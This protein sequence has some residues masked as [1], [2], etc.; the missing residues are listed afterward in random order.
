LSLEERLKALESGT[1]AE[2]LAALGNQDEEG[3]AGRPNPRLHPQGLP[4]EAFSYEPSTMWE[5]VASGG[6][7]ALRSALLALPELGANL[8]E[9]QKVQELT[10]GHDGFHEG[11][12]AAQKGVRRALGVRDAA[13]TGVADVIGGDV[14]GN[15]PLGALVEHVAGKG[16]GAVREL[17]QE[18]GKWAGKLSKEELATL[19]KAA[20]KDTTESAAPKKVEAAA[21]AAAAPA[22]NEAAAAAERRI[23]PDRRAVQRRQIATELNLPEDHPAVDRLVSRDYD[24]LTG[25]MGRDAY[26]RA[27]TSG[28]APAHVSEFDIAGMGKINGHPELGEDVSDSIL[29][30]TGRA[31]D[32]M[33]GDSGT[34]YRKGGDEFVVHWNDPEVAKELH[35]KLSDALANAEVVHERPDGTVVKWRGIDHYHGSGTTFKDAS[36][37]LYAKKPGTKQLPEGILERVRQAEEIPDDG[38]LPLGAGAR[39]SQGP[40]GSGAAAPQSTEAVANSG[41][42]LYEIPPAGPVR[43]FVD[44]AVK[45]GNEALRG[46]GKFGEKLQNDLYTITR[47]SDQNAAAGITELRPMRGFTPDQRTQVREIL[48]GTLEP[49]AADKAAA[50]MAATIR[51]RSDDIRKAAQE[52]QI[53]VRGADGGRYDFE[54]VDNH[55]PRFRP[56]VKDDKKLLSLSDETAAGTKSPSL[57]NERSVEAGGPYELDPEKAYTQYYKDAYRQ[58]KEHETFVSPR[59]AQAQA[60]LDAAI[61][62]G[63]EKA[64]KQ[65][66]YELSQVKKAGVDGSIDEYTKEASRQGVDTDLVRRI[67]RGELGAGPKAGETE[68]GLA[69]AAVNAQSLAKM[70]LSFI[71]NSVQTANTMTKF[72]FKNT[73]KAVVQVT[74]GMLRDAIFKD[75]SGI[76]AALRSG[77]TMESMVNQVL[78]GDETLLAKANSA[79]LTPFKGVETFNRLV[80]SQA[81]MNYAEDLAKVV[82]GKAKPAWFSGGIEGA[83]RDL[84]KMGVNVDEL[85]RSGVLGEKDARNAGFYASHVTQFGGRRMDLPVYWTGSPWQKLLFQFQGFGLK[86]AGFMAREVMEP[87]VK[88]NFQP[89]IRFMAASGVL[90]GSA[91]AIRDM[92]RGRLGDRQ[93][94]QLFVDGMIGTALGNTLGQILSGAK[95]GNLSDRL[96]SVNRK[97]VANVGQAALGPIVKRGAEAIEQRSTAPFQELGSD[98]AGSI[99]KVGRESSIYSNVRQWFDH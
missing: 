39:G 47:D 84:K 13:D 63:D 7:A 32:H 53:Q 88:G 28:Q 2:R 72:G 71:G 96:D 54:G 79:V 45:T 36:K 42:S 60:K 17:V 30:S 41:S 65:A 5:K 92:I 52:A 29:A 81:G 55:F 61:A 22:S 59:I 83:E 73:G 23:V 8:S 99:D 58:L 14:V 87:A 40:A 31:L 51:S 16:L 44:R 50:D 67:M 68:K 4:A 18:G 43:G 46:L 93:P 35:P 66:E 48:E 20:V 56:G 33:V 82:T 1:L 76:E 49:G 25:V 77:A 94:D 9:A 19:I 3:G 95:R 11:L 86:Q 69:S 90:G 12:D 91:E 78:Q 34:V 57:T 21:R 64:I 10:G 70:P 24:E 85:K 98:Y 27:E 97:T 38:N 89:L 6:V 62:S 37:E 75:P 26:K 15:L 80:A 74:Q